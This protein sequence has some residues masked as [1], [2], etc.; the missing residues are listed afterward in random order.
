M[1]G[2]ARRLLGA[3]TEQEAIKERYARVAGV[4]D[5]RSRRAV[6]ASEALTLGCGGITAVSRATG[7]L[8]TRL[9]RAVSWHSR[10]HMVIGMG[11]DEE[12]GQHK[13]ERG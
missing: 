11:V 8:A 10:C 4:L 13:G 5:E 1:A 3:M 9:V 2:C 7:V 6:A 12:S